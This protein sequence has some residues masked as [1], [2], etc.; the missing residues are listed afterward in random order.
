MIRIAQPM[1]GPEE[2]AAVLAALR[3]GQLVQG[4]RVAEFE[5]AFAQ[6]VGTSHAVAVSSGTSALVIALQAHG[7]GADD[8]VIV[9]AFTYAATANA[10]LLAGATPVLVDVEPDTLT[11]DVSSVEAA[12]T[13]RTRGVI[14]V[15]VYG[16]PADLTMLRHLAQH[17]GL[18]MIEDAAQ[19]AGATWERRKAGSFGTGC[20]SFYATKNITT[21][22][23]GML[24]TDDASLAER[25]RLLRSQGELVRYRTDVLGANHRM[26]EVAAAL[27]T[28]QLRKLDQWNEQRRANAAWLS[29]NVQGG[30]AP[31][32][33][34]E[35]RHVYHLY[36][37]RSNNRD[38]MVA[39]MRK[40]G[41]EAGVYYARCV[42]QQPFYQERY[43]SQSF[44]IAERA[45]GEVFS[46]PVHPGLSMTDLQRIADAVNEPALAAE[47]SSG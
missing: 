30:M 12:V 13:S 17:K 38:A 8:E 37:L 23:G 28:V 21:G 26:T 11:I 19:A 14:P 7:I 24:T 32:E 33:R 20:F 35:A 1:I 27:G 16:H 40:R 9:P 3:S 36:T 29:S 2:E 46:L 39:H 45:A 44:P 18:V 6:Y 5:E 10:V 25:A 43:A 41:I 15:H 22:E 47:V 34:A 4:P 42:H 31:I